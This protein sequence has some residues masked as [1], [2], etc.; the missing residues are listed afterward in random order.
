MTGILLWGMLS[1]QQ[2]IRVHAGVSLKQH[3]SVLTTAPQGD[4]LN[5]DARGNDK[6][7]AKPQLV[8]TSHAHSARRESFHALFSLTSLK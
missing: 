5:R 2:A 7:S 6:K 3:T 4:N 1:L 8:T